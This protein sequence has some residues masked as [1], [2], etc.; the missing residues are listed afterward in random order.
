[1]TNEPFRG[2]MFSVTSLSDID[3]PAWTPQVRGVLCF[4][5]RDGE[6]LLILKKRGLGGGKINAP[7]GKIDPGETPRE[8]A[9]RETQEEVGLTPHD[10]QPM[11]ELFFQFTDGYALHCVVFRADCCDGA[12]VET[13]EAV[14]R[15]TPLD[16]IPYHEMWADDR[17]WLPLLMERR[18]FRGYFIF[19]G[20]KMLDHRIEALSGN[21]ML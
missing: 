2:M 7:G 16:A 17:D 8:A 18:P 13:E 15:W 12:E 6:I 9:I 14:P 21:L 4:I 10:P 3:W 11:G 19:D 20:D 5:I 1:M